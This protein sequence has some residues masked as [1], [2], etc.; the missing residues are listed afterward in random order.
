VA[1]AVDAPRNA[2]AIPAAIAA[3]PSILISLILFSLLGGQVAEVGWLAETT[4]TE[5]GATPG[6]SCLLVQA[7]KRP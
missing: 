5:A 7:P 2:I 3:R 1:V 6:I 4:L